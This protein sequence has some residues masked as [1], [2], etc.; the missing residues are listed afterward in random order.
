[1][2]VMHRMTILFAGKSGTRGVAC[3]LAHSGEEQAAGYSPHGGLE[4]CKW[5]ESSRVGPE[6]EGIVGSQGGAPWRE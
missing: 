6:E 5:A 1:M 3:M 2:F 4:T